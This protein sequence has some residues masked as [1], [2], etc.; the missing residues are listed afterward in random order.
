[1]IQG[2]SVC[3]IDK[4]ATAAKSRQGGDYLL[5]SLQTEQQAQR[6]LNHFGY[7]AASTRNLTLELSHNSAIDVERRLHTESHTVYTAI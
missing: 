1:V 2:I 6:R 3:N 5:R 7:S 4:R